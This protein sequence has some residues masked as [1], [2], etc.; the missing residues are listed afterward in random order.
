MVAPGE[1]SA[2]SGEPIRVPR[3]SPGRTT[4]SF[5]PS[6]A[7]NKFAD[8]FPG[9]RKAS[10]RGYHRSPLRGCVERTVAAASNARPCLNS[11]LLWPPDV[12]AARCSK[13]DFVWYAHHAD[14]G[15]DGPGPS[16]GAW[17]WLAAGTS[18]GTNWA[19]LGTPG[20]IF[21]FGK[22][23]DTPA[24]PVAV[25]NCPFLSAPERFRVVA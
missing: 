9:F 7:P 11:V 18:R 15:D 21:D 20:A 24:L 10:T 22:P 5:A 1:G 25:R 12:P 13:A 8:E 14:D 19:F 6:G 17:A 23:V 3:K 2:E 4:D 16:Q